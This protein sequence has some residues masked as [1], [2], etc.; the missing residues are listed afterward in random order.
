ME[1]VRVWP[2]VFFK[3]NKRESGPP[4]KAHTPLYIYTNK[5]IYI[6]IYCTLHTLVGRLDLMG[7]SSE[8][9]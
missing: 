3:E 6:Y 8:L 1:C 7:Q 5:Y 9:G 4:P 2:G